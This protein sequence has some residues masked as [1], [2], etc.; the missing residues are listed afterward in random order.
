MTALS[1]DPRT[2]DRPEPGRRGH[3]WLGAALVLAGG[4][5]LLS[6]AGLFASPWPA[7]P[8][9]LLILVGGAIV[10]EG[11]RGVWHGTLVALAVALT[12]ITALSTTASNTWHMTSGGFGERTYA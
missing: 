12:V 8:A 11:L 2:F 5:L 7:I 3:T 10:V 1:P 4:V 9:F 6:Q